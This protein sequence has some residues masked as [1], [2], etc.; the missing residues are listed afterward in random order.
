MDSDVGDEDDDGENAEEEQPKEN[1]EEV[2]DEDADNDEGEEEDLDQA[3]SDEENDDGDVEDEEKNVEEEDEEIDSDEMEE[4]EDDD[5]AIIIHDDDLPGLEQGLLEFQRGLTRHTT[6][7]SSAGDQPSASSGPGLQNRSRQYVQAAMKVLS[8]QHPAEARVLPSKVAGPVFSISAEKALVTSILNIVKPQKKP[9]DGKI[10]LRRAPTQEEFFRGSLSRNPVSLSMLAGNSQQEPTVRSLRQHIATELQM[11]D[12]AEMLE[13]LIGGKILD[14]D[15]KLRVVNQTLWKEHCIQLAHSSSGSALS[16]LLGGG[17]SVSLMVTSSFGRSLGTGPSLS[18]TVDSPMEHFPPMIMTYRLVGVDGEATEDT[19]ATLSDPEAP[20]EAS[21]PE[22][23][24][25]LMEEQFGITRLATKGRGVVCLIRSLEAFIY[26]NLRKI[27]RDDVE[28]IDNPSH[29]GRSTYC[30]LTLLTCCAKL[31]SNRRLLLNARAPTS[32]LRL[33]LDVL[34]A[35]QGDSDGHPSESNSTAKDLKELIEVLAQ[36]ISGFSSGA[37][38]L[39]EMEEDDDNEAAST[40]RQLIQDIEA[41]TLSPPLRNIIARLLPYLTYGKP[42][43]S[44]ELATEFMSHVRLSQLGDYDEKE[45]GALGQTQSVLMDTFIHASMSLPSNEVCDSLR[46]ELLNCGFVERIAEYLFQKC[47]LEPP[48]WHAF[49]WPKEKQATK[50]KQLSLEKQWREYSKRPGLKSCFDILVGLSKEHRDTQVFLAEIQRGNLSFF[51]FCHWLE[52]TSDHPSAGISVKKLALVAEALLDDL[53]EFDSLATMQIRSIRKA[54]RERK[55]EIAMERRNKTLSKFGSSKSPKA[56]VFGLLSGTSGSS[57]T[58]R[59]GTSTPSAARKKKVTQQEASKKPAWM[60]E[61]DSLVDETG[62][63][64]SVCQEGLENQPQSLLGIYVWAKRVTLSSSESRIRTS[65]AT[66]LT[67][68]P[69]KLPESIQDPRII[70]WYQSGRA[71][72]NEV[73]YEVASAGINRKRDM[74]YTTTVSAC[75]AIHL[76]CHERA[77]I[78]DR[79]HPKAPKSEWEGASLRNSRANCNV[80]LPLVS[81]RSSRVSLGAVEQA[82]TSHQSAIANMMGVQPKSNLWTVL[83][84]VRLLLLRMAYGEPLNSDCGGGSLFSNSQLL[85]YQLAMANSF[86][87]EAQVDSPSFSLHARA[88]SAGFLAAREIISAKDYSALSNRSLIRGAAD[89]STMAPVTAILFHNTYA[90]G[91]LRTEAPNQTPHPKRRW[92]IAKEQFLR[93]LINCAGCR[94]ALGL[95]DSGCSSGRS[96]GSKRNRSTAFAE[97]GTAEDAEE[98]KAARTLSGQRGKTNSRASIDDFGQSLRPLLIFYAMIDQLSSDYSPDLDDP[99]IDEAASRFVRT[100]ESCYRS[101]NIHEL[102]EKANVTLSH[103]EIIND[104]Q[105]GM[106]AA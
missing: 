27:R 99:A 4:V 62:L 60:E 45:A 59:P 53:V 84:D 47:P 103:S 12:S 95:V 98:S 100:I 83:H 35:L 106:T 26:D 2:E 14:V 31:S 20:S 48:S 86:D 88:I 78:A 23:R 64:C 34:H 101:K 56:F 80:I 25:R 69:T 6:S 36:D 97:W 92:A 75:N 24:E 28:G 41:S 1:Q 54:T 85:F 57:E 50:Q 77:R 68:L 9:F 46:V 72:G 52:S 70:E 90:D 81:S 76:T 93:G 102:L 51:R 10:C 19:V 21:S 65:G 104:L 30:G 40:L 15:L 82:L 96:A 29:F 67:A 37:S 79:N 13:L 42:K 71:A 87:L 18:L 43:L 32:L 94:H 74:S 91:G 66:L 38:Q 3:S 33:L 5:E 7:T 44:K 73:K 22:E 49:L 17:R 61:M 39:N 16:S 58:E 89:S 11:A 8:I 105:Q 55:K 63:V